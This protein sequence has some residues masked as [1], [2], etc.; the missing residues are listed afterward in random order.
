MVT[1]T[2]IFPDYQAFVDFSQSATAKTMLET[3]S[4]VIQRTNGQAVGWGTLRPTLIAYLQQNTWVSH[5]ELH[6][7][8]FDGDDAG[9]ATLEEFAQVLGDHKLRQLTLVVDTI[10]A[11]QVSFLIAQVARRPQQR[12]E[13]LRIQHGSLDVTMTFESFETHGVG[14]GATDP[15]D[16]ELDH[17]FLSVTFN[18]GPIRN[19]APKLANPDQQVLGAWLN[20][21]ADDLARYKK[22][23]CYETHGL[24][25]DT[26]KTFM[27]RIAAGSLIGFHYSGEYFTDAEAFRTT[28]ID[29]HG[30]S[31]MSEDCIIGI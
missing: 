30:G 19:G 2:Q 21:I 22:V 24:E 15:L 8:T 25:V 23:T 3:E 11:N 12:L 28:L 10:T 6:L 31:L 7:V 4:L 29:V 5:L 26:L 14:L 9:G 27:L 17:N 18:T 13:K 16:G 20:T 1:D